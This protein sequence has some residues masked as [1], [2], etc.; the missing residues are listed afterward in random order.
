MARSVVCIATLSSLLLAQPALAVPRAFV[1]GKGVDAANCGPVAS[2]CRTPQYAHNLVDDGGE[3]DILDPAGYGSIVIS[4]SI[5]IVNDGVG[6][7]GF[8]ATPQ[9]NAI[10]IDTFGVDVTL[11]GLTIEGAGTG[12]NGIYFRNG[13]SLTVSDCTVQ[14]FG[15]TGG[16]GITIF[17]RS[18]GSTISIV[19]TVASN[20]VGGI[21]YNGAS[22]PATIVLDH[23]T[24][25]F[26]TTGVTFD[27]IT[28]LSKIAI[29]NHVA[30]NNVTGFNLTGVADPNMPYVISRASLKSSIV[31]QNTTG[32][33]IQGSK[34]SLYLGQTT[35]TGNVTGVSEI[36][37][38][39]GS[40]VVY[41]YGTNRIDGNTSDVSGTLTAIPRQ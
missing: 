39:G 17:T 7:A 4:K 13:S 19:N 25:S 21:F 20:N 28:S 11:R 15:A 22:N 10:T 38:G 8:L 9:G 33:R 5:S 23:V 6:I 24:T 26:N 18:Q 12:S 34:A 31:A 29:S 3:I 2:P 30:S 40:P 32:V 27:N 36:S 37:D 35:I 16:S 41:S 14:G 1:S